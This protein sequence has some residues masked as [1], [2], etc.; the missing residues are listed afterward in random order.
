[1][2]WLLLKL[3]KSDQITNE[4]HLLQMKKAKSVFLAALNPNCFNSSKSNAA[5]HICS[6]LDSA[7]D[8][9]KP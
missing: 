7:S 2:F 5:L 1:M 3:G 8:K 4:R 9:Q 6:G